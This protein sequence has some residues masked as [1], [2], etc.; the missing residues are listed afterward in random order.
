MRTFIL[1]LFLIVRLQIFCQGINSLWSLGYGNQFHSPNGGFNM[2]FFFGSL[3]INIVNRQ[4][5]YGD[6]STTICD[7]LGQML[8]SS[9]G[10]Y[11]V[12]ALGDTMLN[13]SGLSP[14]YYTSNHVWSGLFIPQSVIIIPKP[15][16]S[17]NYY[18]VHNT[19]DDSIAFSHFIYYSEV[20][21]ALNGGLGALISKNNM[22]LND[23]MI[24]GGITAV[25]HANGRDWWLVFHKAKTNKFYIYLIDPVGINFYR[26][27]T[28]G[29]VRK[30]VNG[31]SCFSPNGKKFAIY[32]PLSDL[33]IVDFDRCTALFCNC[34][35]VSINDSAAGGGVAFSANSKV[36]YVSSTKYVYQFDMN[37]ADISLSKTTVA[38]W[39]TNYSPSPPAA[40]TYYLSHIAPDNKI[41]ICCTNGT[42]DIHVID[43][44]DS[45]GMSCHVCQHCV[46]LP[47]YNA[48]TMVNHPNYFLGAEHGSICDSLINAVPNISASNT[49]FNLFP[50]P[51]RSV[52]YITQGNKE[53]I[54]LISIFNSIGQE[55]LINYSSIKNG[56]Y[57]EVNVSTLSPGIYFLE[58]MSDRQKVVKK[59]IKE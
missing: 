2:N 38:V 14:A 46:H 53:I 13:G 39:D 54:K 51:A 8:F 45:V 30:H 23:T 40:T 12:N 36:L 44:P 31:Q 19:V 59:F 52:L 55:Q 16:S 57:M 7:S 9:N 27:D 43:Y 47:R 58:M 26:T 10:T 41:Y 24:A 56:E 20:D 28:I 18:L 29:D 25:K 42:L 37:A 5:N 3:N 49:S 4:I 32:D 50:N 35:H 22:I 15:G 11:I 17:S 6:V 21:M 34:I 33:D 1:L 48:T